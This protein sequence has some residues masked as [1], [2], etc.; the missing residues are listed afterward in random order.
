[1]IDEMLAY[2]KT[3]VQNQEYRKFTTSKY[4]NKKSPSSPAWTP[5]WWSCSPPLW[6]SVTG[7]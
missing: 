1:M 6:A 2:N 5:G 3:F 4:P 7:T